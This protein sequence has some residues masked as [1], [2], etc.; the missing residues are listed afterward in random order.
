MI[1]LLWCDSVE[2]KSPVSNGVRLSYY[3]VYTEFANVVNCHRAN[4]TTSE[5]F[6][7]VS[8]TSYTDI[9]ILAKF[10]VTP[11]DCWEGRTRF[12][13]NALLRFLVILTWLPRTAERAGLYFS[14]KRTWIKACSNV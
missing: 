10:N 9:L 7:T 5:I 3:H 11:A 2:C 4:I 1:I 14:L 8:M 6:D 13:E 12:S